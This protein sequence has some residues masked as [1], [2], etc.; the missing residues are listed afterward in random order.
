M[1]QV[2]E[3][4]TIENLTIRVGP[5]MIERRVTGTVEWKGGRSLE[6]PHIAVYSGDE[7]VRYVSVDEEGTFNF[8]LYGDYDYSIEARDYIYENEGRSQRIKIPP[9]NSAGLK[10]VIQRLKH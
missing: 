8:V 1:I 2:T 9:G 5:R 6:M 4:A 7:Y 3:G 10:L